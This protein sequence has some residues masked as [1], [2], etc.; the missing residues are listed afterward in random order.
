[1]GPFL[2]WVEIGGLTFTGLVIEGGSWYS[3][4]GIVEVAL[5]GLAVVFGLAT[6]SGVPGRHL[7]T[8]T[9][10]VGVVAFWVCIEF[11]ARPLGVEDVL[12]EVRYQPGVFVTISSSLGIV[13]GA[14]W[15][16]SCSPAHGLLV[17]AN[18]GS[19]GIFAVAFGALLTVVGSLVPWWSFVGFGETISFNGVESEGPLTGI[20]TLVLGVLAFLAALIAL[21]WQGR[22]IL[23]FVAMALGWSAAGIGIAWAGTMLRLFAEVDL[24]RR[25]GPGPFIV[26][27]GGA[28]IGLGARAMCLRPAG[29]GLR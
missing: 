20:F 8:Y 25:I 4:Y 19:A 21:A 18:P 12:G 7:P 28:I 3:M 22:S 26:I 2:P 27:A 24:G 17:K 6:L 1:M 15:S 11:I 23:L 5:A 14:M 9:A 13:A 10:V 16:A 29:Q